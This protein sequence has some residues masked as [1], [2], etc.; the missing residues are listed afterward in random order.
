MK[1]LLSI[2]ILT[3]GF[4]VS[5]QAQKRNKTK[6]HKLT[7]EQK[8]DLEIKKMTLKLD[9]TPAQQDQVRPLIKEQVV[10]KQQMKAKRKALRKSDNKPTSDEVYLVKAQV[11][12]S[13]IAN[14]AEMKR[15][16]NKQQYER[17]EKMNERKIKRFVDLTKTNKKVNYEDN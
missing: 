11:L 10:K 5:T 15:I 12:D 13:K 16:L 14:K 4:T 17:F 6:D 9:L 8:T 2:L 3:V 1:K 7:I